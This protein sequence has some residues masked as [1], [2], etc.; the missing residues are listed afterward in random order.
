MN[1]RDTQRQDTRTIYLGAAVNL[2]K[3]LKIV[4][5]LGWLLGEITSR[6]NSME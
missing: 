4:A 2:G 5:V 6:R 3:I 1:T